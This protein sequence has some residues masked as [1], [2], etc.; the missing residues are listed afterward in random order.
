MVCATILGGC[1]GTESAQT[2]S[3]GSAVAPGELTETTGGVMGSVLTDELVP[4][5]NA[6]VGV[7]ALGLVAITDVNGHFMIAGLPEGKHVLSAIALGYTSQ[8]VTVD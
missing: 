7:A 4:I 8:S 3:G 5:A 1:V 2:S 6:Q